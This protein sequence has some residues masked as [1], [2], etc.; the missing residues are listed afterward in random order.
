MFHNDTFIVCLVI[1]KILK[2]AA[3]FKHTMKG[4]LSVIKLYIKQ[5]KLM[6]VVYSIYNLLSEYQSK[7]RKKNNFIRNLKIK[8]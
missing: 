6:Q 2:I 3:T 8:G 4:K 1:D 5:Y 7:M